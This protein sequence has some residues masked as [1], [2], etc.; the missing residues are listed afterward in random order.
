MRWE[1]TE[2]QRSLTVNIVLFR[3]EPQMQTRYGW[4]PS[5]QPI[6]TWNVIRILKR[7]HNLS[8]MVADSSSAVTLRLDH[9]LEHTMFFTDSVNPTGFWAT[10]FCSELAL[11][12]QSVKCSFSMPWLTLNWCVTDPLWSWFCKKQK[13]NKKSTC[14]S[15]QATNYTTYQKEC[16]K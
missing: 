11:A 12:S 13:E 4:R 15:F 9:F 6:H 7:M 3:K 5:S 10:W 8:K 2:N 1:N 16:P 14:P